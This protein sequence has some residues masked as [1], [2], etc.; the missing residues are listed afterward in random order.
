MSAQQN[1][2][3]RQAVIQTRPIINVPDLTGFFGDDIKDIKKNRLRKEM[4][5]CKNI[6][7]TKN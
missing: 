3:T 6:V 2:K 7:L 4:F 1:M 5:V